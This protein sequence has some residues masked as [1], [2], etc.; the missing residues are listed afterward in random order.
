MKTKVLTTKLKWNNFAIETWGPP[1][2]YFLLI[3]IKSIGLS[4]NI[5]WLDVT[6]YGNSSS[7]SPWTPSV[8]PL[9]NTPVWKRIY[10]L[11]KKNQWSC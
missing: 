10:S 11:S 8:R 9:S 2:S 7:V 4:E 5:L 6:S 3:P 1:T